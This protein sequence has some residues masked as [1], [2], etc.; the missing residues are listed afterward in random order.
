MIDSRYEVG[1]NGVGD[2]ILVVDTFGVGTVA[3][4]CFGRPE[5]R[6][7]MAER[8]VLCLNSHDALKEVVQLALSTIDEEL[9]LRNPLNASDMRLVQ[10]WMRARFGAVAADVL[11]AI[12]E[13]Q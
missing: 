12:K 13:K 4:C 8:I 6:K 1:P 3:K 9:N 5:Q 7:P 2:N 10:G 11:R